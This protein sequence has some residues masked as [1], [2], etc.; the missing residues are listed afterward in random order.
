[1]AYPLVG[2]EGDFTISTGDA[3]Y[4]GIFGTS[5]GAGLVKRFSWTLNV[6]SETHDITPLSATYIKSLSGLRSYAATFAGTAFNIPRIGNQGLVAMASPAYYTTN[7]RAW[8]LV[9][10]PAAVH[11]ITNFN[12]TAPTWRSFRPDTVLRWSGSY[13]CDVDSAAQIRTGGS[14]TEPIQAPNITDDTSGTDLSNITLTY[15]DSATDETFSGE[16]QVTGVSMGA[17]RGTKQSATINFVGSGALA[18]AGTNLLFTGSGISGGNVT[19]PVWSGNGSAA[20]VARFYEKT[21]ATVLYHET[22]DMFWRRMVISCE[23]GQP[24]SLAMDFVGSGA[25]TVN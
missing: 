6:S 17:V 24:V 13:T 4:T 5:L 21:T 1:M 23:V 20:L 10:E 12:A 11:D 15:G 19:A 14:G 7:A 9:L 18:A 2:N 3:F 25:L 16:V 22:A 8:T